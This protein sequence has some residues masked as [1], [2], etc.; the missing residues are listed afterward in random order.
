MDIDR[1]IPAP[2]SSGARCSC[3]RWCALRSL[4]QL[5]RQH[6]DHASTGVQQ[7]RT[8]EI[9]HVDALAGCLEGPK[10]SPACALCCPCSPWRLKKLRRRWAPRRDPAARSRCSSSTWARDKAHRGASP[11]RS[12]RR[13]SARRSGFCRTSTR[14]VRAPA[15]RANYEFN[16]APD[17]PGLRPPRARAR[18]DHNDRKRS[19]PDGS[20]APP[21]QPPRKTEAAPAAS[22]EGKVVRILAGPRKGEEARVL[23]TGNG[24]VRLQ[25]SDGAQ[26]NLR[27]WDLEGYDPPPASA[28]RPAAAARP[29]PSSTPSGGGACAARPATDEKHVHP[30]KPSGCSRTCRRRSRSP[31][32]RRARRPRRRTAAS[33]C[34]PTMSRRRRPHRPTAATATTRMGARGGANGRAG[35]VG[36]RESEYVDVGCGPCMRDVFCAVRARG[37]QS[38]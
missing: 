3:C 16:R 34:R 8:L 24:W 20:A 23:H 19:R 7:Q 10:R 14:S 13:C 35:P 31:P 22:A 15:A 25:L 21:P 12:S 6:D 11:S 27:S 30:L 33:G 5:V 17:H 26:T 2:A 1:A 29:K 4:V 36:R 37:E 28:S 18:A 38:A 9:V 32:P